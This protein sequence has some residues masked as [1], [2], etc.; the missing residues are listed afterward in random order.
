MSGPNLLESWLS[1]EDRI[2]TYRL[3]ICRRSLASKPEVLDALGYPSLQPAP[4]NA[5]S[6]SSSHATDNGMLPRQPDARGAFT[7]PFLER[8]PESRVSLGHGIAVPGPAFHSANG[9]HPHESPKVA[10]PGE[11]FLDLRPFMSLAPLA[12]RCAS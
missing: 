11:L 5:S 6:S 8:I 12:I 3:C 9:L 2:R 1:A 7:P 10:L 4:S